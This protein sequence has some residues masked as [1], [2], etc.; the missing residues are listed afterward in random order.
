M[1]LDKAAMP[2]LSPRTLTFALAVVLSVTALHAASD[3]GT[4]PQAEKPPKSVLDIKIPIPHEPDA[5]DNG[6]HLRPSPAARETGAADEVPFWDL[7]EQANRFYAG[8]L[9]ID[10][11]D[12][13]MDLLAPLDADARTLALLYVLWDNFGRDGLHTFFYVSNGGSLAPQIRDALRDAGL[14]REHDIF[15]RAMALFGKDYPLD[16]KQ[17]E[18]FFGWS[19]PATRVDA[20]TSI[21]APLNA[22]DDKMMALARAFG[23]Q[24]TFKRDIIA[25]VESKPALWQDV[26]ARRTRLNEPERLRVLTY[27]LEARVGDLWSNYSDVER[28]LD[29][30]SRP[31]RTLAVMA[32]FNAEFMNGGVDQFF[33]NS[34]GALAP[35]V[36]DA[37]IELGMTQQAA[38]FK[39]GLDLFGKP[40]VRDTARRR[41]AKGSDSRDQKLSSLTDELY[42]L[43]GGLEFHRIKGSMVVEGG[44]GID[45]AMLNYARE[46]K[47]L[48]C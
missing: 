15:S 21:P 38:I 22:F 43:N 27:A 35:D 6:C 46:H 14:A 28:R 34:S 11:P 29:L 31:E 32:V 19:Q 48:P 9:T 23:N 47:L 36:H 26:E 4:G 10:G 8:R 17:R 40:Y 44:P 3:D 41:N 25:Y 16:S 45:F 1:Q 7:V 24:A 12:K 18:K 5:K 42:A 33:Y 30:M 39:R 37:M 2:L 13:L 20:V